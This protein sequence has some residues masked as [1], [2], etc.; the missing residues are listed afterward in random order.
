MYRIVYIKGDD[1]VPEHRKSLEELTKS[2]A[3]WLS[4]GYANTVPQEKVG[5]SWIPVDM[6]RVLNS[7][8]LQAERYRKDAEELAALAVHLETKVIHED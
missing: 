4:L 1:F 3:F 7:A 2:M 8:R 5:P 6:E